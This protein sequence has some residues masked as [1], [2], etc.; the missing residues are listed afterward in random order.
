MTGSMVPLVH[1]SLQLGSPIIAESSFS[2]QGSLH[3]VLFIAAG[4]LLISGTVKRML[5]ESMLRRKTP[6]SLEN[7]LAFYFT[8]HII[9]LVMRELG[10]IITFV[11]TILC[12]DPIWVIIGASVGVILNLADFPT[13]TKLEA[14]TERWKQIARER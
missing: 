12:D 14:V 2:S 3:P 5:L 9:S 6:P 11:Y 1:V 10:V 4:L 8:P 7:L 13:K